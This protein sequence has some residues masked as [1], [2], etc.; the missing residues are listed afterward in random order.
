MKTITR[1]AIA[2][3]VYVG[4]AGASLADVP[5]IA[6][7]NTSPG[8]Q[9]YGHW[10]A[11]WWQWALGVPGDR[12]PMFDADGTYCAERQLGDVWFLAG[13]FGTDPVERSCTVPAGT[14]LFFPLIN[15]A[16][17]AFLNDPPETRTDEA[18]RAFAACPDAVSNL[19]PVVDGFAVPRL[20]QFLVSAADSPLFNVQLAPGNPFG[21]DESIVPELV[22]SPTAQEGYYVFLKPLS[23]GLHTIEV[24]A[25]GCFPGFSQ[26]LTFS[27]TVTS[28]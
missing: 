21:F 28:D 8:G 24:Y 23:A 5:N 26:N 1:G 13:S 9:T 19:S 22:F 11:E 12:N 16:Y 14:S 3:L 15:S 4:L 20:H 2:I 6:P 10:A 18:V 7:V 27:I 17:G 25:E